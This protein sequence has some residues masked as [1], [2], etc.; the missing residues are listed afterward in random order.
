MF[1]NEICGNY[2]CSIYDTVYSFVV[3]DFDKVRIKFF[4]RIT[5]LFSNSRIGEYKYDF[6]SKTTR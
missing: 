1:G 2:G 5:T 6:N 3:C 4:I